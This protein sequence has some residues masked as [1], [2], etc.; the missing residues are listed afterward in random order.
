MET[1]NLNKLIKTSF[2]IS[3]EKSNITKWESSRQHPKE[4]NSLLI[5]GRRVLVE[6]Q[7]LCPDDCNVVV[8]IKDE[9]DGTINKTVYSY[10]YKSTFGM[11]EISILKLVLSQIFICILYFAFFLVVIYF[12]LDRLLIFDL[13]FFVNI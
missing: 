10:K 9:R 4:L 1:I 3:K 13:F 12:S 2:A 8:E 5:N 7:G 11:C 6:N